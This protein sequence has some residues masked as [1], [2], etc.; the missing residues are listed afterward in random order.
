LP[1]DRIVAGEIA[2]PEQLAEVQAVGHGP[3]PIRGG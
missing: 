1:C 3:D 2:P